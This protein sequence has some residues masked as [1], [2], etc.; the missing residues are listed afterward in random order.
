MLLEFSTLEGN[1]QSVGTGVEG[2][3]P[4]WHVSRVNDARKRLEQVDRLLELL[5]LEAK[6]SVSQITSWLLRT[7]GRRR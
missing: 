4:Q 5:L 1:A 2:C 3:Y 6:W 7:F